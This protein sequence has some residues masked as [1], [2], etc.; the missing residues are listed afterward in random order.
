MVLKS[1]TIILIL[2]FIYLFSSLLYW[3]WMA[4]GSV[5]ILQAVPLLAKLN[6]P[7]PQLWPSLSVIVPA[8]NEADKLEAAAQTLLDEDYPNLQIVLVDDR[9]TDRTGQ[10]IDRLADRDDRVKAIHISELP[11]GWMGKVNA[12]NT[13]LA[14]SGGEFLL[15]TDADVHFAPGTFRK[16]LSYCLQRKLD[17]LAAF[18]DLWPTSFILDSMIFIFIRHFLMFISRPWSACK[19]NSRAFLGIGAFNLLRRSAF[20]A[21]EGFEW[22][23]REVTDD[24]GLALLMKR[25]GA[26]C[27]S[28]AAFGQVGLFWYTS[29]REAGVGAEKAYATLSNF[30]LSRTIV[31]TLLTLA[32]EISPIVLLFFL[33]FDNLHFIGYAGVAVFIAF[34]FSIIVVTRWGK[35]RLLPNLA[36]PLTVWLMAVQFIRAGFLGFWRGGVAWRGTLYSARQFREGKRVHFP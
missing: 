11:E 25:S 14:Q 12:L 22:L 34:V 6:P 15:F 35:A 5:R 24:M 13:G 7:Q 16:A 32:M 28:V 4:Y 10:I 8:R 33:F 9:S 27:A 1:M 23:R 3:L 31:F 18:P 19:P 30:S 26:S 29:I 17:H 20:E 36:G 2:L 21:T